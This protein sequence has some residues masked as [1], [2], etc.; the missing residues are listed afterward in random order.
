M[1]RQ[2]KVGM[3]LLLV[4]M[5]WLGSALSNAQH[6]QTTNNIKAAATKLVSSE[7]LGG[8][9]R[10][11][12]YL[13]LDKPVYKAGDPVYFRATF[14]NAKDN[15]PLT[16]DYADIKLTIKGPKGDI[17]HSAFA[18]DSDS[19]VGAQ[20]QIPDAMT[21]GQYTASVLSESLGTPSTERSFE[22]R[23]YRAPRLKTHI[24]FVRE[25][26]GAGDEVRASIDMKRA[27]GGVPADAVIKVVARVDG[28]LVYEKSDISL[29]NDG[30]LST[31]FTLPETIDVGDGSLAFIIEDGGVVETASKSIPIV[32]QNLSLNFY[33]EGG[34]LVAGLDNRVY[35][36]ARL[37]NGKPAD[38]QGRIM[39]LGSNGS[40]RQVASLKTQHEG[41]GIFSF[42]PKRATSY[43]LVIDKPTGINA[44]FTLPQSQDIGA[45]LKSTQAVFAYDDKIRLELASN[46]PQKIAKVTLYKRDTLLDE[47]LLTANQRAQSILSVDL[48]PQD[49]EGVLI[50]T[51]WSTGGTPLA[52]RLIFREPK[53]AVNLTLKPNKERFVPGDEVT[54]DV[55]TTDEN[56]KPVEA[57][58][59]LTVSDDSVREIIEKRE[60]AARLPVMVY[61][62]NE[63]KDLADAHIYLDA[64]NEK[65]PHKLDLLLGTQG[66]RRFLLVNYNDIKTHSKE[67]AM[68]ALAQRR[69]QVRP[70]RFIM[71]EEVAVAAARKVRKAVEIEPQA[72]A[73]PEPVFNEPEAQ[74]IVPVEAPQV[75][76]A[77]IEA[78]AAIVA[79]DAFV[80]QDRAN[81]VMAKRV[82]VFREYAHQVR[83]NRKANDRTDF[84]ETLYWH[85]GIRTSARDGKASIKFSLSD[86]VTSFNVMADAFGRNGALGAEQLL[87]TSTEPFYLEPKMPL[88]ASVGDVIEIPIA[89]VNASEIDID[90]VNVLMRAEG[91][92]IK[93]GNGSALKAG[94][95]ARHVVRVVANSPGEYEVVVSAAAGPFTDR[96][97]RTLV[98]K[99][100]GFPVTVNHGGLVGPKE[101]ATM[102]V[103]IPTV[104][105]P[106]SISAIAKVYPSPLANMEEALNAL[107]RQPYGCFEQ[108]SSTTYPLVMAQQYFMSHHGI[109]PT[110]IA[111]AKSLLDQGYKKL[112]SYESEDQGYEWFGANPAH[113]ALTAYGLME[114]VD[115][116]KV[117]PVDQDMIGRTRAWL[118]SRRDGNGGFKRNSKSL[119][120]FGSAPVPTTNAYIVWAM[121]E[122]GESPITLA[123]EIENVK[124][125]ALKSKDTYVIALAANI[126]YLAKDWA[127]ANDLSQ[128]LVDA[129]NDKGAVTNAETSITRSGGDSL[130]IETTSLAVLAWLRNDQQWAAN[131]EVSMQWLFERSKSG[132]FG[133]TQSTILALKAINAYDAA[134]AKP[135]KAGRVQLLVDGAKFG[136]PIHFNKD[137]K[138]AIELPDFAASLTPG[139][140]RLT[141]QMEDGSSMPFAIEVSYNTTLPVSS[142][143][144]SVTVSTALSTSVISEGEPL[145][146]QLSVNVKGDD[147]PSPMV[148]VG[149]PAGLEV[150]HDRLKELVGDKRISSYEVLGRQVILYWRALKANSTTVIPIDVIATIPGKF[151]GPASRSYLYYTDEFKHWEEGLTVQVNAKR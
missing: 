133:S 20:W 53:F 64:A 106:G 104:F 93:H 65:A 138:G 25:G 51:L 69:P 128:V 112:I 52:E 42:T 74:D 89:L 87:I 26:Y 33:P 145:E 34:D 49:S 92:N 85:K 73:V 5:A 16:N 32:L 150:R 17:V 134:R 84:T 110:K 4:V 63:V 118:L 35:V 66:W 27:E 3:V 55:L 7:T 68:R 146:L 45:V 57:V 36:Q 10:Y 50:A 59:G 109:A 44:R 97:T 113:E 119:D 40:S 30:L 75:N 126:L 96:V 143:A 2:S 56:G 130:T 31:K 86:S 131:T 67:A 107:L 120:S 19:V 101:D 125:T 83:P 91:L 39:A 124:Q 70:E 71:L 22:I 29:G 108:A 37:P 121:L 95:R 11:L 9:E 80:L 103:Q 98:V 102:L 13:A 90:N 105:E 58:V 115:M 142:S 99:P 136:K 47:L 12:V 140:H 61:L 116:A 81:G 6:Q 94:Q 123:K 111:K 148:I 18:S 88:E 15:T 38:I 28:N 54:I 77:Q 139:E 135:K 8:D 147:A 41:R 129:V 1:L 46:E 72:E 144:T 141:L 122:S 151:R 62:E 100:N 137:T 60:Q 76:Q 127:T 24:E 117:M 79:D 132:R 23:A 21:G 48:N 114:F 149:I 78:P 43:E 14:L 82:A